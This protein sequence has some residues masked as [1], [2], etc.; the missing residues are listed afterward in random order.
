LQ[1]LEIPAAVWLGTWAALKFEIWQV[2]HSVEVP[3]YPDL[4][5]LAQSTETCDPVNGKFV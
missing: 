1:S 4:W 3:A 2:L 5:Q